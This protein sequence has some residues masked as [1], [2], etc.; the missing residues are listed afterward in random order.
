MQMQLQAQTQMQ[1]Q[2]QTQ[3]QMQAQQN[4]MQ[5][6]MQAQ[7]T[8][9]FVAPPHV[10]P[11]AAAAAAPSR[12]EEMTYEGLAFLLGDE[13]AGLNAQTPEAFKL[14]LKDAGPGGGSLPGW[15]RA[16]LIRRRGER[17]RQR[18]E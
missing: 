6:Q 15:N 8:A 1:M 16:R 4:Q 5:M 18:T 9:A 14:T 13:V 12:P 17:K 11:M 3:M 10:P 2:A 7:A